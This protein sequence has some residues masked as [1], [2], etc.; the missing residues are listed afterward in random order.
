MIN[1]NSYSF[2]IVEDDEF[3]F[4]EVSGVLSDEFPNCIVDQVGSVQQ[5]I[6]MLEKKTF[7]LIILDIALP[8]HDVE[9]GGGTPTSMPS[10][11]IEILMELAFNNRDEPVVV[12]TQYPEVE[13]D[14]K[15]LPLPKL[16]DKIRGMVSVNLLDVV[17]FDKVERNWIQKLRRVMGNAL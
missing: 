6:F 17:L 15:L 14:G 9:K 11:G 5:A 3:K 1:Q 13:I 2:L 16:G 10:G 12:M 7:D 8:S 4:G